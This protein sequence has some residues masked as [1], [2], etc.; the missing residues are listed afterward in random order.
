M[1]SIFKLYAKFKPLIS[2]FPIWHRKKLFFTMSLLYPKISKAKTS[3]KVEIWTEKCPYSVYLKYAFWKKTACTSIFL[4]GCVKVS[5]LLYRL[6]DRR[7][8]WNSYLDIDNYEL[9]IYF[10]TFYRNKKTNTMTAGFKN[11]FC[12]SK[13]KIPQLK[14][15]HCT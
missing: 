6:T 15:F 7:G 5:T 3:Q 9:Q 1:H 10:M 4:V 11:S 14:S 12:T 13:M 8:S 2:S